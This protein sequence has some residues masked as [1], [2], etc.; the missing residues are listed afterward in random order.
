ML[1]TASCVL[2]KPTRCYKKIQVIIIPF[3]TAYSC[4]NSTPFNPNME[5]ENHHLVNLKETWWIQTAIL[6]S[7]GWENYDNSSTWIQVSKQFGMCSAINCQHRSHDMTKPWARC[8]NS[9]SPPDL[10]MEI[11]Q[12]RGYITPGSNNRPWN[13]Q[14][15][16]QIFETCYN[17]DFCF[18]I[19]QDNLE[20]DN[21]I[22]NIKY[23]TQMSC[24][25]HFLEDSKYFSPVDK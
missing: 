9:I 15:G 2:E 1:T 21:N 22:Y 13:W 19:S 6:Y 5:T 16:N 12:P 8:Q 11:I 20:S 25:A 24:I 23:D 7:N 18:S 4:S 10:C 14:K 17:V 3:G